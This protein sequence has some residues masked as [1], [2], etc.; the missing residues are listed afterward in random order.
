MKCGIISLITARKRSQFQ[1]G[2]FRISPTIAEARDRQLLAGFS[3]FW[4]FSYIF[5]E[6]QPVIKKLKGRKID[7]EA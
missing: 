6:L 1:I 2:Q 3:S 7:V 4:A 5:L